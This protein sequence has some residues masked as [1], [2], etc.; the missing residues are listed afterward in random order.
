MTP[1]EHYRATLDSMKCDIPDTFLER[2]ALS[3]SKDEFSYDIVSPLEI[4]RGTF[5]YIGPFWI[6]AGYGYN[7]DGSH[8]YNYPASSG[9]I[10]I[11][12]MTYQ[13]LPFAQRFGYAGDLIEYLRANRY[14]AIATI[15]EKFRGMDDASNCYDVLIAVDSDTC[16][17]L[18][19]YDLLEDSV[20]VVLSDP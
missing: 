6:N 9:V 7:I 15:S 12:T 2:W 10:N 17:Y 19:Y 1:E 20:S 18:I 11:D 4:K 3:I 8:K 16:T 14:E 5:V 13:P